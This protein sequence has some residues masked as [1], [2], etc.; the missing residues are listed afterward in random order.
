MHYSF[1]LQ[2]RNHYIL[3]FA[4]PPTSDQ[5]S[6]RLPFKPQAKFLPQ[7]NNQA[8]NQANSQEERIF[9]HNTLYITT[10]I[11]TTQPSRLNLRCALEHLIT[12]V[13]SLDF[14]RVPCLGLECLVRCLVPSLLRSQLLSLPDSHRSSITSG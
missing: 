10:T 1:V 7:A 3:C 13:L 5:H 6:R 9:L 2:N 8:N 14:L 4:N 11:T 12:I